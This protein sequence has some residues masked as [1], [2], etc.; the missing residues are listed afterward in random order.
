M[1]HGGVPASQNI[2]KIPL[3]PYDFGT[4]VREICFMK[5]S[6]LFHQTPI[7]LAVSTNRHCI[8]HS[9]CLQFLLSELA[10]QFMQFPAIRL[11]FGDA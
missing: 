10:Q 3:H 7:I 9:V 11:N 4:E 1:L 8:L 2:L 6:K 5:L